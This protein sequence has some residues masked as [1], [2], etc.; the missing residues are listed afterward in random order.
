MSQRRCPARWS[1]G[2]H[3]LLTAHC[4]V[5]PLVRS[6]NEVQLGSVVTR[7][8][9][10]YCWTHEYSL[11]SSPW[12]GELCLGP[13][14]CKGSLWCTRREPLTASDPAVLCLSR[15]SCPWRWCRPAVHM[16]TTH[17]VCQQPAL[18]RQVLAPSPDHSRSEHVQWVTDACGF[19]QRL[20]KEPIDFSASQAATSSHKQPPAAHQLF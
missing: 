14:P 6:L 12:D 17:V 9:S 3:R 7:W 19:P 4:H 2:P 1:W 11:T 5:P 13:A 20:G 15:V 18:P 16:Y 8:V 10:S